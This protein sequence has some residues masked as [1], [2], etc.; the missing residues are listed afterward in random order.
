MRWSS[1]RAEVVPSPNIWYH[2]ADYEL[3]NRA[4][5]SGG[6]IW[7]VLREEAG[8]AGRDVLDVGCGDGFHLPRFA[9]EA[10]SVLGI[11]PHEPLVRSALKRV[12]GLS[13]VD[14]RMGRAQRLPVRSASVDVVHARTA[15]FFG[16][17]CEPG[18]AEA[19]RVLRPGGTIVIVDLDVT[20]E[21]YGGWMRADLPH[22]DPVA[23]ERFFARAGFGLRRVATEWRFPAAAD[24]EA[25]LKI[26]FSK[27]VAEQAIAESLQRNGNRAQDLTLPVGYRVHTRVK[28]TGLVLPGHSAAS[29]GAEDS[30]SSS[31]R[32]P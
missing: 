31:P 8:W 10:R 19:E 20:S 3:E 25:V 5:D 16:P 1:R 7:R 4:Q 32:M 12:E 11:E 30:S 21:P 9:R 23:V 24:L 15:Y 28:P 26:E 22:Y 27:R 14:V 17:G 6:E 13:N 2:P 29:P 18:L